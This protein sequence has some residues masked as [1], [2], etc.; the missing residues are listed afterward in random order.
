[1]KKMG[2]AV[3]T[4]ASSFL[5]LALAAGLISMVSI[6]AFANDES[7]DTEFSVTESLISSATMVWG[8]AAYNYM[9]DADA[10]TGGYSLMSTNDTY[11][12][13]YDLRDKGVVTSVKLQNP[14]GTCWAFAA[15]AAAETSYLSKL[16]KTADET[17]LDF[18]EHHLA[19]FAKTH[20]PAEGEDGYDPNESQSGEGVWMTEPQKCMGNGTPYMSTNAYASGLGPV[21]EYADTQLEY[22]G[23]DKIVQKRDGTKLEERDGTEFCYWEGDDWS[24]DESLRFTQSIELKESYILPNNYSDDAKTQFSQAGID[25]VK[26]QL[27]AGR[28]VEA[29]FCADTSRPTDKTSGATAQYINIKKWCH[30]TWKAATPNH[31][32]CIVGWDDNYSKENFLT[33]VNV[34]DEDGNVV[35]DDEGNPVTQEVNQPAGDGAWIVKN[36][37]GAWGNEFPNHNDWG[38][39]EDGDGYG[40]GY[41][42]L[43]YYDRSIGMFEALDFY[44]DDYW[45]GYEDDYLL[46]QY[47]YAPASTTLYLE[48]SAPT[49][50]ANVFEAESASALRSVSCLTTVPGTTVDYAVYLVDEDTCTSPTDGTLVAQGSDSFE[51]GGFHHLDLDEPVFLSK[52]QKYAVVE[53]LY[54]AGSDKTTYFVVTPIALKETVSSPDNYTKMIVNEGESLIGMNNDGK[55]NWSGGDWSTNRDIILN[56]IG[57]QGTSDLVSSDNFSIKAYLDYAVGMSFDANGGTGTMD[58]IQAVSGETVTVPECGFKAPAGKVFAGWKLGDE[59]IQ[60]GTEYTLTESVTLVAQW[61]DDPSSIVTVSFDANGG[62]GTMDSVTA[63][64]GEDFTVPACGFKAPSGKKFAGWLVNGEVVQPG[65]TITIQGDTTL[66]AQWK[67]KESKKKSSDDESDSSASSS[68]SSTP[69]TGDTVSLPMVIGAAAV[70]VIAAIL[71]IVAV[72]KRRKRD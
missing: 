4:L 12:E 71:A 15:T 54:Y 18:S 29:T 8:S 61:E 70:A 57:G 11:P 67:A 33:V 49:S 13:K 3:R 39:D 48:T 6:T 43:S 65:D 22:H 37:W 60:P 30:Y 68:S 59:I 66:V 2:T 53:T 45:T 9:D 19:W 72:V 17:G 31:A 32:V 44:T 16:G 38:V 27:M 63:T 52:G 23:V 47:D 14:W 42:Y 24:I 58:S 10:D 28:G 51:Y 25:A 1:M 41:F 20:L 46:E 26:E 62:S 7:T 56:A 50:I 55:T 5:A 21:A 36:S 40:D 35:Y 69:K 64:I 34:L